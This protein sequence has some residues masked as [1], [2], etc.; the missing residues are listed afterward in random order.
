MTWGSKSQ[1]SISKISLGTQRL[2][3]PA[4]VGTLCHWSAV[5][6]TAYPRDDVTFPFSWEPTCL[7]LAHET[8]MVLRS[9]SLQL[10]AAKPICPHLKSLVI[11][12]LTPTGYRLDLWLYWSFLLCY[13]LNRSG[14]AL[15]WWVAVWC[16]CVTTSDSCS[17]TVTRQCQCGLGRQLNLNQSAPIAMGSHNQT[18]PKTPRGH[19]T[20]LSCG[21]P[22]TAWFRHR[23]LYFNVTCTPLP[24]T[25]LKM[26]KFPITQ[27]KKPTER[28]KGARRRPR[29]GNT[30]SSKAADLVEADHLQRALN[31]RAERGSVPRAGFPVLP[32]E[33]PEA[34]RK[35]LQLVG[36]GGNQTTSAHEVRWVM[37]ARFC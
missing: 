5:R 29:W 10:S 1:R 26:Q 27:W 19:S 34:G 23:S 12:L 20:S 14:L 21:G 17:T 2:P 13:F 11:L 24:T 9:H 37:P 36:T 33:A 22:Q 25:A 6:H 31:T 32:A 30:W 28:D 3:F 4:T 16:P 35:T 18:E 15:P 8:T 7:G